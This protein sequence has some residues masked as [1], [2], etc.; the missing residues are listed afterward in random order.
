MIY[1]ETR[2]KIIENVNLS[3]LL[4]TAPARQIQFN[5]GD[6]SIFLQNFQSFNRIEKLTNKTDPE[7]R[8]Q[9][10]ALFK[11][12]SMISNLLMIHQACR[13]ITM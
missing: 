8:Y 9:N 4:K 11:S 6:T 1:R 12:M 5:N 3:Y 13:H 2:C 7:W 10:K